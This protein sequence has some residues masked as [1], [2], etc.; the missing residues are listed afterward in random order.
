MISLE[1][2]GLSDFLVL[3][4]IAAKSII[5]VDVMLG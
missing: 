1:G 3:E 4:L 5:L 2:E